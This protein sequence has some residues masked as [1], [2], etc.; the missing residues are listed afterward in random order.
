[1]NF[2][3]L[4]SV[5]AILGCSANL[6]AATV[7]W[8]PTD[9]D[10]NFTYTTAAGYSLGIFDVD[11]FDT[12]Q[13]NPLLLNTAASADTVVITST[14]AN[15]TATS[16][17]TT[18]FITLF[19]DSQFVIALRDDISSDWYEPISWFELAPNSNI[20]DITFSNGS[21][22]SIDATP[23]VVPVPAAVWLFGTGLMGL[24]GI[25]RRRKA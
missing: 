19:D 1:M 9:G 3:K 16:T 14:G 17:V 4:V 23:T 15:F 21:V 13:D 25:A 22:I 8:E 6:Q 7:Y 24:V 11:N 12:A 18:N 20:Y 5:T 10:V 2:L